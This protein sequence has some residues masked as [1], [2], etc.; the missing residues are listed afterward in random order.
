MHYT[1]RYSHADE[2]REEKE[3]L[4]EITRSERLFQC[5]ISTKLDRRWALH[6]LHS[7]GRGLSHKRFLIDNNR[8]KAW[9]IGKHEL[10]TV[11]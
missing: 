9:Q 3:L 5:K 1:F 10:L 11:G 8:A 4:S 7:I 2:V 6:F